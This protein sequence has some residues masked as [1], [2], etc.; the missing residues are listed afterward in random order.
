MSVL[1]VSLYA[2]KVAGAI[3]HAQAEELRSALDGMLRELSGPR[4]VSPSAREAFFTL[5]DVLESSREAVVL[6][7]DSVLSTQQAADLLGVSRMTVVRLVDR[8]QLAT[9]G[10]GVHRR[11]SASE[12]ARYRSAASARRSAGLR[13]LAQEI[14]PETP[15]DEVVRTR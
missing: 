14:G 13:E 8:G 4:E 15:P 10:G 12:L 1:S 7:F 9:A 3:A 6:P 2:L 5:I 11:I